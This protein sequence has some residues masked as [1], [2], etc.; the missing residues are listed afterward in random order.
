MILLHGINS[1]PDGISYDKTPF[2]MQ[3]FN[4]LASHKLAP[5]IIAIVFTLHVS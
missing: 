3:L 1:L 4:I 2:Y 5:F